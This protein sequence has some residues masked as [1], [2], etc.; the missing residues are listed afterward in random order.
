MPWAD[1][2][3][4][5]FL[6]V[7]GQAVDLHRAGN[8]EVERLGGLALVE[9]RFAL[10]D[11]EQVAGRHQLIQLFVIQRLEQVMAAQNLVMDAMQDHGSSSSGWRGRAPQTRLRAT[12]LA[13]AMNELKAANHAS[14]WM[15]FLM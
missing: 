4:N 7:G 9:Q 3:K 14:G 6:A 10:V 12:R 8:H 2:F 1:H 15:M 11:I 13:T 5:L